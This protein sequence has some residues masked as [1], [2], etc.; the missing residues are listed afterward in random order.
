MVDA[1]FFGARQ[2]FEQFER[3]RR[4]VAAGHFFGHVGGWQTG[5]QLDDR[6]A[7]LNAR[8]LGNQDRV[9]VPFNGR[10]QHREFTDQRFALP[11]DFH[12]LV[13]H[14]GLGWRNA[15]HHGRLVVGPVGRMLG[16]R[17]PATGNASRAKY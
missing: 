15:N 4:R 14:A 16:N 8:P 7:G 17:V 11:D 9:H 2:R 1:L 6:L 3:R 13:Q 10:R 12:A 5:V